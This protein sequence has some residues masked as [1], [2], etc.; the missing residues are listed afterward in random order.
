MWPAVTYETYSWERDSDELALIPKSRRRKIAPTYQ[1]AVPATIAALPLG[2]APDL[3]ERSA[4]LRAQ[5]ARFD[6]TQQARGYNLPALLLRSESASSSQIERLTSSVRNVALAELSDK[7]GQNAR[8]IAGNVAAMREAVSQSKPLSVATIEAVHD[9]LMGPCPDMRGLRGQQVW[10]GG[11]SYSPHGARFVPP[12]ATRVMSCLQD[13]VAFAGRQDC[14]P[15]AKA[16]VFHAQFETIHPFVDGNGRTG[17]ALLHRMLSD[18]EVLMHATL[19][20]S[21]GLL[22]NVDAYMAALDSYH[23][24][25]IEPIVIQVFDALEMAIVLGERMAAQIDGIVEGWNQIISERRGAAAYRL[26]ALLVDQPVVNVAFVARGLGISERAAR[27]LVGVACE[28]GILSAMGNAK[29]GAFYQAT[30]LL[31]VLEEAS[32]LSGVRRM[33]AGAQAREEAALV[34]QAPSVG[35][36]QWRQ[37]VAF[38]DSLMEPQGEGEQR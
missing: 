10:I 30:Q 34:H 26:S 32:Q 3:L 29:R 33:A 24:G 38:V 17:R 2:L 22:H 19:P 27:N 8:L 28:R 16:A 4:D 9:A 21:A 15:V 6:Q 12:H 18:D 13:L 14:D 25:D 23:Q 35:A 5:I 31:E 37:A 7:V 36:S 20:V 11:T 1:A